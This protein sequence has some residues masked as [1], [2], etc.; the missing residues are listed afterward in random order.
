MLRQLLEKVAEGQIGSVPELA[1]ALDT[2]PM[3]VEAMIG[4]LERRG[5]LERVGDCGDP[6][7]GC[8]SER[9]CGPEPKGSAWMLTAAGRRYAAR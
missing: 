9:S 8:P 5:W 4:T 3:M 7:A 2:S 6:C 1:D